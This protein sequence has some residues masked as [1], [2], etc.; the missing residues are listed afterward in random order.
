MKHLAWA[1]DIHLNFLPLD[2][3]G[4]FIKSLSRS[5][6]DVLLLAGDIGEADSV[7]EYLRM[8]EDGFRRPIYFVLGNHDFYRGS[9]D[10]TRKEVRALA[11]RSRWLHWLGDS[12]IVALSEHSCLIGCDSW[13]DGRLGDYER[14]NV[15]LN[16]YRLI[17][18]FMGCDKRARLDKLHELG[19]EAAAHLRG[20]LP[21]T[22]ERSRRILVLVHVP[23]FKEACWHE[24]RPSD[25]DFLPHFA[26]KA[27]GDL[28]LETMEAHP[29]HRMTVLCGH[30]HGGGVADILPNLHVRTG[31]A[32]Y[33]APRL[34]DML[35]IL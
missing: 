32:A 2:Q 7:V 5:S 1:T 33:G 25:D 26:C 20:L 23:P 34:Q 12:D 6:P 15:M 35:E 10:R 8:I 16:D 14:S 17:R 9:I 3:T 13:A 21:R 19:D 30:T 29:D 27:V 11:E 31:G 24:G 4:H 18:E 28:L 22:L